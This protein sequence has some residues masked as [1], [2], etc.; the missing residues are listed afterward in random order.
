MDDETGAIPQPTVGAV[1]VPVTYQQQF[2]LQTG[3]EL[4]IRTEA[5]SHDLTIEGFVRDSQMASSLSSATRFLVSSEDFHGLERA[6]GG[7][8]EI[9]VEYRLTDASLTSQF[10]TA[11]ESDENLPKNGQAVTYRMIQ[12]VNAFGDGLG[13]VALIFVSLL[14]MAIA[15]LNL[16]FV[17]RGTVEDEV[18]EIGVTAHGTARQT[19]GT[20]RPTHE[21][22]GVRRRGRQPL[23]GAA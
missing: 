18:R 20:E 6:G 4:A 10:Q 9:I 17:I 5:G 22:G 3:D 2:G 11:Y 1:Y 7:D 21:P 15:L 13:A 16:R 23:A 19:T 12:L 14:L 8:P